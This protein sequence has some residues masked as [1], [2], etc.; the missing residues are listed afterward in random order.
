MED[1]LLWQPVGSHPVYA[2]FAPGYDPHVYGPP[3]VPAGLP[4]WFVDI[5]LMTIKYELYGGDYEGWVLTEDPDLGEPDGYG[6]S[7]V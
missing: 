5:A 1:I 3:L 4:Y 2:V 6:G 7:N